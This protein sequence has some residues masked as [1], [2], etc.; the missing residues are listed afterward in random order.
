M[1]LS[2]ED[3]QWIAAQ[4]QAAE[5]RMSERME[6]VETS[7]LTEFH[8]WAS[9]FEARMRSHTAVLRALDEEHELLADR[10]SKLEGK[11]PAS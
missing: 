3:K 8:K 2:D 6:R 7:L 10:V 11:R 5:E 1:S 4:L 9:P